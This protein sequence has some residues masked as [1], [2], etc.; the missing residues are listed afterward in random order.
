MV[1]S[2]IDKKEKDNLQ[3]VFESIDENREG[4]ISP[5]DF[6]KAFKLK[7][8][9]VI[10]E[11]EIQ[12]VVKD[13]SLMHGSK[14]ITFTEFLIAASNKNLL[15]NENN[16]KAAFNYIDDDGDG[17]I[18]RDD[19][20]KFVNIDNEYFIGNLIEEADNDCDGGL[21]YEEFINIMSKLL[22]GL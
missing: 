18:N 9:L 3:I 20:R 13:S 7:F 5:S 4:E 15:L 12:K 11:Q 17:F 19:Y 22:K 1:N 8:N 14:N 21:H 2:L 16:L 6:I 10:S